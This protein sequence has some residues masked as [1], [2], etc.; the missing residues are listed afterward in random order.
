[1]S[2]KGLLMNNNFIRVLVSGAIAT[3]IQRGAGLNPISVEGFGLFMVIFM[4]ISFIWMKLFPTK[5]DDKEEKVEVW[6]SIVD[7]F[8]ALLNLV[9]KISVIAVLYLLLNIFINYTSYKLGLFDGEFQYREDK[10]SATAITIKDKPI[11]SFS[12][13]G[14]NIHYSL[15]QYKD[16]YYLTKTI[17]I[18][19]KN[20]TILTTYS[21]I[22][23]YKVYNNL[24]HLDNFEDI[25]LNL[26]PVVYNEV[27]EFD[28]LL[29]P[30]WFS[31]EDITKIYWSGD[32]IRKYQSKFKEQKELEKQVQEKLQEELKISKQEQKKLQLQLLEK[33]DKIRQNVLKQRYF[34][35]DLRIQLLD[36]HDKAKGL[37]YD[38][39]ND[40]L[41]DDIYG[42]LKVWREFADLQ[43]DV[44]WE[45]KQLEPVTVDGKKVKYKTKRYINKKEWVQ[46]DVIVY[47]YLSDKVYE[48]NRL[49]YDTDIIE[50]PATISKVKKRSIVILPISSSEL[51]HYN[52]ADTLNIKRLYKN[53]YNSTLLYKKTKQ[54]FKNLKYTKEEIDKR[55]KP[56]FE[57]ELQKIHA[58]I[59]KKDK[60]F[61]FLDGILTDYYEKEADAF[62]Y[63][64]KDIASYKNIKAFLTIWGELN[65]LQRQI[66]N[67][68]NNKIKNVTIDTKEY[69]YQYEPY[70]ASVTYHQTYLSLVK[71]GK[72][73]QKE[74]IDFTVKLDENPTI[75][76]Y[77]DTQNSIQVP[78]KL[79]YMVFN[80]VDEKLI[81]EVYKLMRE[82]NKLY[83]Q[84]KNEF[85]NV[86]VTK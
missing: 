70:I 32:E 86:R 11:K 38:P 27:T 85:N 76:P 17:G 12:I 3:V 81:K 41:Y 22:S 39:L 10:S 66:A 30:L 67:I 60:S 83:T 40:K 7:R 5:K 46:T 79:G 42:Y 82:S 61:S 34:L 47:D 6:I 8:K 55:F 15:Y 77:D 29:K 37:G 53:I 49:I 9:V 25:L 14:T 73:E 80:K 84:F 74:K 24:R 63:E 19:K 23:L 51:L 65:K 36:Y 52:N 48:K 58:N 45:L 31:N 64:Y 56:Y 50:K 20:Q 75:E 72:R 21:T 59:L 18:P 54:L 68:I 16:K 43:G 78:T 13:Y 2:L 4:A 26:S 1:M 69:F 44:D 33:L 28:M 62:G 57:K 35:D 71:N